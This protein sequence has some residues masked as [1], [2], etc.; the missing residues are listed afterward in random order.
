LKLFMRVLSMLL[1]LTSCVYA[2][3]Q[4]LGGTG[5]AGGV[6]AFQ[7]IFSH[8]PP[9]IVQTNNLADGTPRS[10]YTQTLSVL[11]GTAPFTWTVLL[12]SLPPGLTINS[13][14]G[15]ISGT[16]TTLGNF[17]FTVLVT[18]STSP[19][20]LSATKDLSIA[21]TCSPLAIV[22]S[23]TL[24]PALVGTPYQFQFNSSGG[25]GTVT[26]AASG[27]SPPYSLSSSGLLSG[28][29][30]AAN[31]QTFT[32]TATDSCPVPRNV[33]QIATLVTG[34]TVQIV[35][36]SPLPSGQQGTSYSQQLNA[37]G[38]ITPYTWAVTAGSLPNGLALGSSGALT[39]TPTVAGTFS[40]TI[41]V[42]DSAAVTSSVPFTLTIACSTLAVTTATL[43]NGAQGS[44]YNFQLTRS[45]GV[46]PFTWSA[47]GLPNGLNISTGGA[48]TGTPTRTGT[49][50][51]T[52]TV[53]D[54]CSTVQSAS[55]D[56][57]LDVFTGLTITTNATLPPGTVGTPYTANMTAVGGVPP[58]QWTN[59]AGPFTAGAEDIID[60]MAAKLP[61][62]LNSHL[63]GGATPKY[64]K[65]DAGVLWLIKSASGAPSDIRIYDQD[66]LYQVYTDNNDANQQA[67]CIAAGYSSC[68]VDPF[69]Y[70]QI[71]TPRP[72]TPRYFVPGSTVTIM[73]P[74][75]LTGGGQVNPYIKTTNCGLDN[76][77]IAYLGNVKVVTSGGLA[78]PAGISTWGGDV[79][80][81]PT[82]E[83]DY[84]YSGSVTGVY[85]N[86]ERFYFVRGWGWVSWDHSTLQG[87]IYVPD[88]GST[89]NIK[90]TGGAPT[91]NFACKIPNLNTLSL[92]GALPAGVTSTNSP[93]MNMSSNTGVISGTPVDAGSHAFTVQVEDSVGT[94]TQQDMTMVTSCPALAMA[95]TSPLSLATQGQAYNFQF[96]ANGG[97]AP[98]TWSVIQTQGLLPTGITLSSSGVLSGVPT[99]TGVF[100]FVVQAVDSCSPQQSVQS[101][102]QLSVQA[103][104][105]PLAISTASPL[106]L[107]TENTAYSRQI[108]ASGGTPPYT[109][110]VTVGTLPAGL[111]MSSTGLITGTP[112]TAGTS[113]FTVRVTDALAGT[114]TKVFALTVACPVMTIST[115]S[116]PG[117]TVSS[118]YSFQ[119][120]S[121]GGIGSKSWAIASGALPTGLSLASSGALTGTPTVAGT[122]S[123]AVS[124]TDSCSPTGQTVTSPTLSLVINPAPIPLAITTGAILPSSVEGVAYSA[125]MNATGGTTPYTWSTTGTLPGGLSLSSAGTISGTPTTAGTVNFPAKVTDAV[126]A[127]V[128][129]SESITIACPA[130][131]IN[132]T[133]PL[134]NGVQGDVYTN[135][136]FTA[137]GG[138]LPLTWTVTSGSFPTGMSMNS[139]GVL[140][141][142]PSASGTFTVGITATDSCSPTN[143]TNTR[144]FILNIIPAL[145][146]VTT[147]PLQAGT[148]GV[149]YS[150][151][152]N[153]VGGTPPYAW[154]LP[155]GTLPS[156]LSLSS[157]GVISGT[158]LATSVSSF[159]VRVT[160][161]ATLTTTKALS[162]TITCP[163]L[164]ITSPSTLPGAAQNQ[165]YSFQF[166]S[167]GGILPISWTGTSIPAGLALSTSGALTGTPTGS[168]A[169]SL[170]ITAT[171]SC[172][173][174]HQT[175]SGSFSLT[176]TAAPT[177]VVIS[178][179]SPLPAATQGVAYSTQMA[180]TGG[181][182]PYTWSQTGGSLPAGITI[183]SPAGII[184]G[185]PTTIGTTSA[186]LQVSDSLGQ[187]A[188]GS[189]SITV[190]CVPL[191]I[192]SGL[193]LPTGT[194]N[195]AYSNQLAS[196]GG[197]GAKSWSLVGGTL[198]TGVTLSGGGLVAGT[199]STS[200]TFS[201]QIR[202][203]DSCS[204]PQT[205]TSTFTL[206]INPAT[207]PLQITTGATLPAATISTA[208]SVTLSATG[209]TPPYGSWTVTVGT[210]PTGL[211]LGSS[212]GI[213]SGTPTVAGS[214][215]F[216]VRVADS[217]AA[218]ATK[219][220]TLVVNAATG[221]YNPHCTSANTVTNLPQDGPALPLAAC[222]NTAIA[223]TP[224]PGATVTVTISSC[225]SLQSAINA[226]V[227]GQT[228]VVPVGTY[229][230]CFISPAAVGNA[231][232]WITVR[233]SGVASL[234]AEGTRLTPA[235]GGVTTLTGRP[236]YGQPAVAGNYLPKI[237]SSN[238]ANP[239]I[240]VQATAAYWRF[241]GLE[242]TSVANTDF[243]QIISMAQ[244]ANHIIFDRMWIN[245]ADANQLKNG[246]QAGLRI[247]SS[248]YVALIDSTVTNIGCING[249]AIC[250]GDS[251]AVFLGGSAC[252]SV[253]GPIKI[254]NNFLEVAGEGIFSGGGG[255]GT[256][257][258][259]ASDV[260]IARNH[261]FK[262]LW[263]K[264][265]DP[266]YAGINFRVKNALEFKNTVRALI[267]ANI[268]EN[269]WPGQSDQHGILVALDSRNQNLGINGTASSNGTGTLT[270]LTG[271]HFTSNVVGA[272]CAV[273]LHCSVVYNGIKYLAQTFISA[274]QI[275]VSP[276]PPTLASGAF[277]QAEPGLNP[278]AAV[279]DM[280]FRYNLL[281]HAA[282]GM[283]ISN[284]PS[285]NGDLSALNTRFTVHDLVMDDIDGTRWNTSND[286]C[287]YGAAFQIQ[288]FEV[289]TPHIDNISIWH[290]TL[291]P[292][293]SGG[294]SASVA[295]S[296]GFGSSTSGLIGHLRI[297]D[298][299]AAG[300]WWSG[301]A[302]ACG[303][304]TTAQSYWNCWTA[305]AQ[306]CWD[307]NFMTTS[308]VN[309]SGTG[310]FTHN[311]PPY[312]V[313]AD[314]GFCP[315]GAAKGNTIATGNYALPQFTNLNGAN[316]GNYQLLV[317][318]PWH[319][320]ASDGTDPGVNW[321]LFQ[322]NI[323]GVQ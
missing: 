12:G 44:P 155:A 143:S 23:A 166:S 91:P 69:A 52:V 213:I 247:N 255:C 2:Q 229:S 284:P 130:V 241:I 240:S 42:N 134:P 316:G 232:N 161:S 258:F 59:P 153:A 3:Q 225:A 100:Q 212:T 323:A 123:F 256:G 88:Q 10:A 302:N 5:G 74:P 132:S 231:S 319:N 198:P 34:N 274:N 305:T 304:T 257:T 159:T 259:P 113:S 171:D 24:T 122:F 192:T 227:A 273:P 252:N 254:T 30:T 318:S 85:V 81:Q 121:A 243:F 313:I 142:T 33:Q 176:T 9:L 250:S 194:Q 21:I 191:A 312:P 195:S 276:A 104:N 95:S 1:L 170:S 204:T 308:T 242:P 109:F 174:T 82:I 286:C 39:G 223:N 214:S 83:T 157:G 51:P 70:K 14:T 233:T 90:T 215:S 72:F 126:A 317:T 218:T 297:Y 261:V 67:A 189:F 291:L 164:A 179:T 45:G 167:S 282:N 288:N 80:A 320:K 35:T 93:Q 278:V 29:P 28:T 219:A 66:F 165:P 158:P 124:V 136:Q 120:T 321:N 107:A 211:S 68:F 127:T 289:G 76:Q 22:S 221:A 37:Q 238:N 50:T 205:S 272:T 220:F 131:Q 15:V 106:A 246:I 17:L 277:M 150:A 237:I 163:T 178:T 186:T 210:L 249:N 188:S 97:I 209:G 181:T 262:P 285:D 197:T 101:T 234:P 43:P 303:G 87:G 135:F 160:D 235:W 173:A 269:T 36:T 168:G 200:G 79:G 309:A 298:N 117:G 19:T 172:L 112:T 105:G 75:V 54:S 31:T 6:G 65:V 46:S 296:F 230:A 206:T 49:F 148:E 147:S 154:T 92:A 226:A 307:N 293:Y 47:T 263:M 264:V 58:Y 201:P 129:Q 141:G 128:S 144:T 267:E 295:A 216:T 315:Y 228:I 48:I 25:L 299:I 290:S 56:L 196:S 32:V 248:P 145:T 16:P 169:A 182:P 306:K 78:M 245:G 149:A 146:I 103:N 20:A 199:P 294:G 62:R 40:F 271:S 102:F 99:Q 180:A 266:S 116:L 300:G 13:S 253:D 314:N 310:S 140:S 18:D 89:N 118:A 86:R 108:A 61:D 11:H 110:A 208:Y 38:G 156:G 119:F 4:K 251:Q 175:A 71:V 203:T 55:A 77:P 187:T 125:Q 268:F 185:T 73:V 322:Q 311:N 114:A 207:V 57:T 239:T 115:S 202:V 281:R 151:T 301:S 152:V 139:S 64:A 224:S 7:G 193:I 137:T 236:A 53:T 177:P 184:S 60:W 190:S 275:T 279:T 138:I 222:M 244:G 94:I 26:W 265:G 84:Y 270:W 283:Q 280:T 287:A 27:L 183:S 96:A 162:I 8:V 260:E 63:T 98:L 133:S 111:A 292:T 217:V 41:R